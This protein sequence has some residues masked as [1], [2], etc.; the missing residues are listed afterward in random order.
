MATQY[1]RSKH[2][3]RGQAHQLGRPDLIPP[4]PDMPRIALVTSGFELGGGVPTI[5]RWL[6]DCLRSTGR[7][8]V[9]VHD[10]A[11]SSR[12]AYSRRLLAPTSWLRPSLRDGLPGDGTVVRWGANVVEL[13]TMRYM[14][15]R[16]LR[17]ML[18][19]YDI[20]QVVAG[21]PALAWAVS[22]TGVPVV[23]W[24]AS[25]VA[26]ERLRKVAQWTGPIGLW[27]RAMTRLTTRLES[28]AI[29]SADVVLVLNQ[30]LL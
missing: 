26:W 3:G 28:R 7:Y 6:R 30:A 23:L 2:P 13:E 21:G 15:R 18:Q 29:H 8:E 24:I 16:E 14:P 10:L 11:T 17:Q 4:A 27:R 12:D 20:V 19:K 9:D 1:D 25:I 5:A 22:G